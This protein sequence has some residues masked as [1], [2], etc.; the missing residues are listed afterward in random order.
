MLCEQRMVMVTQTKSKE[1]VH[2]PDWPTQHAKRT[3]DPTPPLAT[4]CARLRG[5]KRAHDGSD[6]V[7]M[8]GYP[9]WKRRMRWTISLRHSGQV[10]R[11][12]EQVWQQ[13]TWP[14][15]RNTTW[16]WGEKKRKR[17][18]LGPQLLLTAGPPHHLP[19][20]HMSSEIRVLFQSILILRFILIPIPPQQR[21]PEHLTNKTVSSLRFDI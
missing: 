13:Q 18:M 5:K 14:Q 4:Q 8:W 6:A 11:A 9:L 17:Q 7:P 3:I 10:L 2:I 12:S 20:A 19:L 1:V 21:L 15:V 16:A